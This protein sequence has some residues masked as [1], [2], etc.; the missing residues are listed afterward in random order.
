MLPG[1][2][3]HRGGYVHAMVA[4]TRQMR[5][6]PDDVLRVL[7]DGWTYANWVVGSSRIRGV[8]PTW[9]APGSRIAHSVGVWPLVINDVTISHGWDP[10]SGIELRARAWPAGEAQVRIE[11]EPRGA[12]CRVR[13]TEEAVRGPVTLIP[14][15]VR[16]AMLV[17]R[18]KETLRRLAMIAEGRPAAGAPT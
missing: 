2:R 14:R 11:V 6:T 18:N 16:S 17:P 8:D 5:C 12:G 10:A 4:L 7:A 9:P 15:R 13:M 3:S 1:C